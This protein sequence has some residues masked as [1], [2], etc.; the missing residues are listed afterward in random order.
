MS[1]GSGLV[2]R[3]AA[4]QATLL[5]AAVTVLL[6]ALVLVTLVR[7]HT[8]AADRDGLR[9]AFSDIPPTARTVAAAYD[10]GSKWPDDPAVRGSLDTAVRDAFSGAFGDIPIT[11]GS[12]VASAAYGVD[13]ATP[14]VSV[15]FWAASDLATHARLLSGTWPKPIG[16]GAAPGTVFQAAVPEAAASAQHW[17]IGDTVTVNSR[18]NGA[19]AVFQVTGVYQP[20]DL[21]SELWQ[22]ELFLGKQQ[23][24]LD[25]PTFGPL[26]VDASVTAGPVLQIKTVGYAATPVFSAV[27]STQAAT[28]GNRIAGLDTALKAA[29][30]PEIHPTV[31][32]TL[33]PHTA[34]ITTGQQISDRLN[35]L[36][37]LQ[38]AMLAATALVLTARLLAEYRRES[39]GLLRARGASVAGLLRIGVAE[40]VLLAGPAA[41]AAPYAAR[42]LDQRLTAGRWSAGGSTPIS[43]GYWAVAFGVAALTVALLATAGLGGALSFVGVKRSKSRS[44]ARTAVQRTGLDLMV[45]VLGAAALW[46]VVHAADV[47]RVGRLGVPQAV[48]PSVLLL[49]GALVSLRLLPLL[50]GLLERFAARRRGAIGAL[51]GWRVGRTARAYAAPMIL[52]IMAVAIGVQATV[53][54]ASAD[55]SAQDQAAYTVGADVRATT[56]PS[57]G[58]GILGGLAALPGTATG[59]AVLRDVASL[60][61]SSTDTVD[62][63]V[64][65]IDPA[66]AAKVVTLRSDQAAR[67]WPA[68]ARALV[69]DGWDAHGDHGGV[70]LPGR[71]DSLAL[72]VR[73]SSAS[74]ASDLGRLSVV[75]A[76]A[77][78]YGGLS[79]I[80]LGTV[81]GP[82]GAPHTLTGRIDA[83]AGTVAYPLRLL[84]V[85][86]TYWQP[87]CPPAKAGC[88]GDSPGSDDPGSGNSGAQEDVTV[89]MS[90]L[91]VGGGRSPVPLPPGFEPRAAGNAADRAAGQGGR[92]P[93]PMQIATGSG[94][95]LFTMHQTSGSGLDD[96]VSLA[97]AVVF[98]GPVR[99]VPALASARLLADIQKKV[100]DT[101][102]TTGLGGD[103]VTLHFVGVLD[104]VPGADPNPTR[105]PGHDRDVL[106][107]PRGYYT[108]RDA[109]TRAGHPSEWWAAA[110]PGTSP[111]QLDDRVQTYLA[112]FEGTHAVADRQRLTAALR[113]DPFA[114]GIR[115]TLLVGASAALLFILVGF[116]LHA[117]TTLRE[118]SVEL[119]LLSALGL[120]RRRTLA[121][122]LVEQA[123]LVL[124][125]TAAGLALAAVAIRS[126]LSFMIFTDTGA[127][128]VPAPHEVV[129]WPMMAG[130]VGVTALFLFGASYAALRGRR[131]AS[132]LVLRAGAER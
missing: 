4:A 117:V 94:S 26:A 96:R 97:Q 54:L 45:V 41:L 116:S 84:S 69:T 7:M 120:S 43:G 37:V 123:L 124:L 31:W 100:G 127:T 47:A 85:L 115:V 119:A 62:A 40:G 91:T 83:G 19:K 5:A 38:L 110:A 34:G 104:A 14:R 70:P 12:T 129:D 3:R 72:T 118:R 17:K 36:Q 131:E 106:V 9:K 63:D 29:S 25:R 111:A 55:R 68:L 75:A 107:V 6:P 22:R 16:V 73:Y 32:N 18:Q 77:D 105:N 81:D 42:W 86:F 11:V 27:T 49:A 102:D 35:L 59:T 51:A 20:A 93:G 87:H 89:R 1:P 46:E 76:V 98:A 88:L 65:G 21:D 122:L 39:D 24:N 15:Y 58:A 74:A 90:D 13:T 60:G 57:G 56:V 50:V 78:D 101:Y 66:R 82:D 53:F 132:G 92:R 108:S 125:G 2:R 52:L 126:E 23:G 48:A 113:D 33:G 80:D 67:P 128:A 95:D 44:T 130:A 79:W 103:P 99:T 109:P 64:L 71:P 121:V 28:L 30:P 112:R 8:A 61:Y 10:T 114:A